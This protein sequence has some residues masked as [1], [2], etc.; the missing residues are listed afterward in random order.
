MDTVTTPEALNHCLQGKPAVLVLYGGAQCGVCQAIKPQLEKALA[1]RYPKMTLLYLDCQGEA[2]SVCA[3][4]RIFSLPV[5]QLWFNGQ[6]FDEWVRTFS[7]GQV[8]SAI[9]RP[10]GLIFDA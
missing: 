5:V 4:Q 10:Y 2:E 1:E 9:E 3:Q 6:K 7:I 8:L